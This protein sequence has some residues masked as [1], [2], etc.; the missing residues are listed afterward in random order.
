[1]ARRA[2]RAWCTPTSWHTVCSLSSHPN[3]TVHP[4]GATFVNRH[5][6]EHAT[7][8]ATTGEGTPRAGAGSADA[9]E[10]AHRE[11]T[12]TEAGSTV[13][14]TLTI[15][16]RIALA[17]APIGVGILASLG[18]TH[19]PGKL[20][21]GGDGPRIPVLGKQGRVVGYQHHPQKAN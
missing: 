14:D 13:S 20:G 3:E 19:I 10:P 15:D 17:R 1:M 4:C 5:P 9:L 12:R 2:T 18:T 6:N 7:T 11:G 21:A 16:E 8:T